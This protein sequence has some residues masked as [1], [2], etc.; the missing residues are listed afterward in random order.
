MV[1]LRREWIR[2]GTQVSLSLER[3]RFRFKRLHLE[4]MPSLFLR[5]QLWLV[6]LANAKAAK[7]VT[8]ARSR[9][10]VTRVAATTAR[11]GAEHGRA[12]HIRGRPNECNRPRARV[13]KSEQ[14]LSPSLVRNLAL[15]ARSRAGAGK[16]EQRAASFSPPSAVGTSDPRNKREPNKQGRGQQQGAVRHGRR[17]V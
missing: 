17:L 9:R 13:G 6:P 7:Q 3:S 10:R 15:L 14:P 12:V 11:C 1:P 2:E 5:P 8:H 16:R 4:R